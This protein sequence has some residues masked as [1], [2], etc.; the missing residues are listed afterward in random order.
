[1]KKL[2]FIISII[3]LFIN[4]GSYKKKNIIGIYFKQTNKY[5]EKEI[6]LNLE[7]LAFKNNYSIIAESYKIKPEK[8]IIKKLQRKGVKIIILEDYNP[9]NAEKF[10][11][12]IK[13]KEILS[14]V[15]T[16]KAINNTHILNIPN[17]QK[18]GYDIANQLY[19]YTRGKRNTFVIMYKTGY[20]YNYKKN[21]T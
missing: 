14:S 11:R 8:N 7:K 16:E 19:N 20:T 15:I 10:A 17:Y 4:C 5:N 13:N 3:S 21:T 1:M 2:L 12:Y 18:L 9:E 6:I